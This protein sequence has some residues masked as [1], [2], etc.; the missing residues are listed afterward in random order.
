MRTETVA[1]TNDNRTILNIEEGILNV[2]IQR[3]AVSAW[4]L[5]T[6]ENSNLLNCL[7]NCSKQVLN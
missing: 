6:V 5:S 4:L 2:E 3:L 1:A 7:R